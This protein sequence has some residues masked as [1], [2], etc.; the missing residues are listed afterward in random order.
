[1]KKIVLSAILLAAIAFQY[2]TSPKKV[3]APTP[4]PTS[5]VVKVNYETDIKPLIATKC[6]PCHIPP[7]GR[8]EA[9]NTYFTAKA[10][11]D[12]VIGRIKLNPG[13]RG[14]MPLRKPKLTDSVIHVFEQWKADGLLE[15]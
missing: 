8:K 12:D 7:E 6:S 4:A 1:M 10:N 13:E 3:Q 5:I 14:F 15:K 11:I 2:C 9:L